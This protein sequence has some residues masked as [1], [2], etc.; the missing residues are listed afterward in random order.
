M[1]RRMCIINLKTNMKKTTKT[2]K[3]QKTQKTYYKIVTKIDGQYYSSNLA[4]NLATSV[5]TNHQITSYSDVVL[6]YSKSKW[7]KPLIP[8]SK[9][10]IFKS[11]PIAQK[12]VANLPFSNTKQC[13]RIFQCNAQNVTKAKY[14]SFYT[15][16]INVNRFW[17]KNACVSMPEITYARVSMPEITR[18]PKGTYLADKVKLTKQII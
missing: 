6:Q 13:I 4:T 14:R 3:T 2:Q 9:L 10:F 5:V 15:N 11:L 8:N 12:Y 1:L 16:T 18:V 17:N 7:T